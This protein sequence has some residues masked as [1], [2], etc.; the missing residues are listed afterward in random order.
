VNEQAFDTARDLPCHEHAA[1][2]HLALQELL[3]RLRC[4]LLELGDAHNDEHYQGKY[5]NNFSNHL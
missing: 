2:F 1:G 3:T 5:D 4:K